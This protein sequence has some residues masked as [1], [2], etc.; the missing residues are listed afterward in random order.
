[1]ERKIEDVTVGAV[2][3]ALGER[4]WSRRR[5]A[6]ELGYSYG[7]AGRI[8]RGDRPAPKYFLYHCWRLLEMP[9]EA[10]RR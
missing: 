9:E 3:R 10:V 5:L 4:G 2:L 6:R 7:H 1:V 8:L